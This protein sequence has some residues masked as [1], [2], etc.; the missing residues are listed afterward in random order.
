MMFQAIRDRIEDFLIVTG[1]DRA[2]YDFHK[3]MDKP[4]YVPADQNTPK[5]ARNPLA[6]A[7][8]KPKFGAY[9]NTWF[10]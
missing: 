6:E 3:W 1:V 5:N 8:W 2:I 4:L 9:P 10:K 7:R